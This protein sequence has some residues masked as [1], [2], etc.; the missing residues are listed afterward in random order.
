MLKS[1]AMRTYESYFEREGMKPGS[2]SVLVGYLFKDDGNPIGL[3]DVSKTNYE[4]VLIDPTLDEHK[5]IIVAASATS[6][7]LKHRKWYSEFYNKM[8]METKDEGF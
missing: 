8:D 4:S 5:Q 3:V 2:K 6:L 7:I 1:P